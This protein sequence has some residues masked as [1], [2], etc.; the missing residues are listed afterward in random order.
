MIEADLLTKNAL[1]AVAFAQNLE[2]QNPILK[3]KNESI[4]G[5]IRTRDFLI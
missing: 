3:D 1:L 4:V 2:S 5:R